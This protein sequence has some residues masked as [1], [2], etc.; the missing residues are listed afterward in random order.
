MNYEITNC[1]DV[2]DSRDVI[3]RI[4]HL[5]QQAKECLERCGDESDDVHDDTSIE[6]WHLFETSLP[7][8]E[9][10]E[11][12]L[13]KALAEEGDG[14]TSEWSDGATLIR[15]S[16]FERYAEELA[17]DIGAI[18]KNAGWPLCHID[19][20]AA[21]DALKIDYTSIEFDSVD[22]WVRS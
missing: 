19:W 18:D 7:V 6:D 11:L 17:D 16:Y 10:E 21:A 12:K 8:E 9:E 1:E 13:L 14:A 22:Y 4:E 20:E 15:Y 2:I 3:A 5:E